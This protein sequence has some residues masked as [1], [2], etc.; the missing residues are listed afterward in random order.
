MR[1]GQFSGRHCEPENIS[2]AKSPTM[3][4]WSLDDEQKTA[5][6]KQGTNVNVILEMKGDGTPQ[7]L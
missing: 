1:A 4:T 2:S 3:R 5:E 7:S 6:K